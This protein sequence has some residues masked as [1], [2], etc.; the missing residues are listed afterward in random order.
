VIPLEVARAKAAE[1]GLDLVEV[2]TGS[3]PHVCRIMDYGHYKFEQ[4]KRQREAKKKQKVIV[5]KEIKMRPRTDEHDYDFKMN[6][7]R[8]FLEQG[9]KVKF[10]VLYRGRELAHKDHGRRKLERVESDLA[11]L[12]TVEAKPKFEGRTMQMVMAPVPKPKKKDPDRPA[13]PAESKQPNE[14]PPQRKPVEAEP[15]VEPE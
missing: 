8:R 13:E 2:A 10:T 1:V 14:E 11:D 9:F 3:V 15:V 7:A 12:A 4:A 5:I 6:H